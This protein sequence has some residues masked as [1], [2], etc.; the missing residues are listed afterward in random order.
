MATFSIPPSRL[1]LDCSA[2]I[3]ACGNRAKVCADCRPEYR[4]QAVIRWRQTAEGMAW[5]QQYDSKRAKD[6]AYR[7][8]ELRRAYIRY[9][10]KASR[11]K[12]LDCQ[13]DISARGNKAIRCKQCVVNLKRVK[14]RAYQRWRR[15]TQ[16]GYIEF[17][18]RLQQRWLRSEKGQ[19]RVA[20]YRQQPATKANAAEL[21]RQYRA[22]KRGQL[23]IV[24]KGT[25]DKLN[26]SRFCRVC[27]RPFTK[28]LPRHID[29]VMP[30]VK[31]GLHD[32]SNLQALCRS[33]NDSK[34]DMD[35]IEFARKH[36]MLL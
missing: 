1:C 25:Q 12:C 18:R 34:Q 36:G 17:Q 33:C 22:R 35:P 21:T 2:D 32:D 4:R 13:V 27:R 26:K 9:W 28:K 19:A 20:K 7:A 8:A 3:S 10:R 5:K 31:G 30:L 14:G 11:R 15:A 29:H 16:P 23:G 6:P 24:T